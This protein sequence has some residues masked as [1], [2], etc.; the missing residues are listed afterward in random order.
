MACFELSGPSKPSGIQTDNICSWEA[1]GLQDTRDQTWNLWSCEPSPSCGYSDD[2]QGKIYS[3]SSC[4]QAQTSPESINSQPI[5]EAKIQTFA[6]QMKLL[7]TPSLQ[8][9]IF[10]EKKPTISS[11][12]GIKTAEA[13]KQN[14]FELY[15]R[16]QDKKIK[17]SSFASSVISNSSAWKLDHMQ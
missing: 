12:Q 10:M 3:R 7:V 14:T 11:K 1:L 15:K 2:F 4:R 6:D 13:G 8:L 17:G 5:G 16:D 9:N